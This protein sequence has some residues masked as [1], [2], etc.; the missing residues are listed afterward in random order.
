[1]PEKQK[2]IPLP[3]HPNKTI[4]TTTQINDSLSI[5][6]LPSGNYAL[7]LFAKPKGKPQ[8]IQTIKIQIQNIQAAT[9][10]TQAPTQFWQTIHPPELYQYLE[11]LKPTSTI[12]DIK[13]QENLIEKKDSQLALQYLKNYWQERHPNQTQ[14]YFTNYYHQ[15]NQINAQ[16]STAFLQGIY[17]DRGR[18][19]L[20][21]GTP[22]QVVK[23]IQANAKTPWELWQYYTTKV[24]QQKNVVFIFYNQTLQANDFALLHS[25]AKSEKKEYNWRT[26]LLQNP[27]APSKIDEFLK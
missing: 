4:Q 2:N 5:Q 16:Y 23:N 9:P 25:N 11:N 17:T 6:N 12:K 22:T 19:Q 13:T 20:Q 21:Y 27:A 1:V 18:I 24:G 26:I 8:Q 14:D 15:I 7:Q 3:S 10:P